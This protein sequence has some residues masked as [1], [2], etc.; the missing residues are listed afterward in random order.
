MIP[1][2]SRPE[3]SRVWSE[4]HQFDLWLKVEIAACEAWSKLGV[5][6]D[7]DMSKIRGAR[8]SREEYDRNFEDNASRSGFVH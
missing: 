1:R 2:Y 4:D 5:I 3:M 7:E 8:F 6:D